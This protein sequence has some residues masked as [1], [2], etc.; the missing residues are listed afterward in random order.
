MLQEQ[1]KSLIYIDRSLCGDPKKEKLIDDLNFKNCMVLR[2]RKQASSLLVL[3]AKK[4]IC[5]G[6]FD[7]NNIF[8]HPFIRNLK[9]RPN[10]VQDLSKPTKKA[11]KNGDL[12]TVLNS[13]YTKY[14]TALAV[15]VKKYP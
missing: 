15:M 1:L 3:Q 8:S 10:E 14:N 2:E 13:K 11:L 5:A 12:R 7:A 9:H 6:Y 4:F